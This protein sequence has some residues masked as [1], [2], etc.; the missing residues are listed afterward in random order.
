MTQYRCLHCPRAG[1]AHRW[2]W[3]QPLTE[4]QR[5]AGIALGATIPDPPLI[6]EPVVHCPDCLVNRRGIGEVV[7]QDG[8]PAASHE[9]PIIPCPSI[10]EQA[11][12]IAQRATDLPSGRIAHGQIL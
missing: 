5:A 12:R 2:I 6:T 10:Q 7:D 1:G 4:Q 11:A 9:P 8:N 3:L